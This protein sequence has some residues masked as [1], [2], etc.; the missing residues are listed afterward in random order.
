MR[1]AQLTDCLDMASDKV[2]QIPLLSKLTGCNIIDKM[3]LLR[4]NIVH[5]RYVNVSTFL[6][7]TGKLKLS[8]NFDQNRYYC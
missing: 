3:Q 6:M 1:Q 4:K 7:K 5:N 2:Q 8:R